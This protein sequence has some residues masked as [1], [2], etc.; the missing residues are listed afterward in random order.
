MQRERNETWR[1][2]LGYFQAEKGINLNPA[3]ARELRE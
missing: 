1:R 3:F 2:L